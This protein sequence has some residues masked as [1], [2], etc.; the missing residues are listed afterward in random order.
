MN[1]RILT[2][3]CALACCCWAFAQEDEPGHEGHHHGGPP[4]KELTLTSLLL[5]TGGA[6]LVSLT[7]LAI[8][9]KPIDAAFRLSRFRARWEQRG[10]RVMFAIG[11]VVLVGVVFGIGTVLVSKN[12]EHD[13][14]HGEKDAAQSQHGGT[15]QVKDGYALELLMRRTGE[16]RLFINQFPGEAPSS[17]DIKARVIP[18]QGFFSEMPTNAIPLK[19]SGDAAYFLTVTEPPKD[20]KVRMHLSITIRKDD[21][22]L[23]YDLPVQD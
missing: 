6:L 20:K 22:E 9:W 21:I 13:H 1:W 14:A 11:V 12:Q 10:T 23:D 2:V 15:V 4:P 16:V 5:S 18:L 19:V 3:V 7:L 17:F 8:L